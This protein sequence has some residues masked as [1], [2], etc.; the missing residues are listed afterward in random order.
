MFHDNIVAPTVPADYLELGQ[1]RLPD[2]PLST[3]F[4][5]QIP[6]LQVEDLGFRLVLDPESGSIDSVAAFELDKVPDEP[7][8]ATLITETTRQ[9]DGEYFTDDGLFFDIGPNSYYVL[10]ID[11]DYTPCPVAVDITQARQG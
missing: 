9:L 8:L 4:H 7:Q 11:P 2:E 5:Q 1:V 10:P 3:F 6:G